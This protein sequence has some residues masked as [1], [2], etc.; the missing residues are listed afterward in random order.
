MNSMHYLANQ[1]PTAQPREFEFDDRTWRWYP[2]DTFAIAVQLERWVVQFVAQNAEKLRPDDEDTDPVSWRLYHEGKAA[3]QSKIER[4]LY[5]VFSV[6]WE[7]I[8]EG[9]DPGFAEAF[10]QCVRFK[11]PLWTRE[12]TQRLLADDERK[13]ILY[14]EW[15]DF[16]HPKVPFK[17]SKPPPTETSQRN[18]QSDGTESSKALSSA[19]GFSPAS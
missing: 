3:A 10:Y 12:M 5:G 4:G 17:T 2:L 15:Q 18:G 11:E 7:S 8:L 6:G 19:L 14:K 9:T 16:N 13:E 1:S